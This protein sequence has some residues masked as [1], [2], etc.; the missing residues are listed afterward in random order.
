MNQKVVGLWGCL[1]AKGFR[2]ITTELILAR[3]QHSPDN[4]KEPARRQRKVKMTSSP[5]LCTFFHSV[6]NHN[7][8]SSLA[9]Y[10]SP[11]LSTRLTEGQ[12]NRDEERE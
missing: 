2:F 5:L 11:V 9:L 10:L 7:T 3:T 12:T 4:R 8:G 1:M 6:I